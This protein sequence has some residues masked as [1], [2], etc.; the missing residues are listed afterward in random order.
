MPKTKRKSQ[1]AQ[2]GR[3]AHQADRE[4]WNRRFIV[5]GVV[6][7]IVVVIGIIAFGWYQT[8]VKPLGKTVLRVEDTKFSL[9]HFERR[10]RLEKDAYSPDNYVRL[11][12]DVL[13]RLQREA[14]WLEGGG[15]LHASVS[16]SEED[17]TAEVRVRGNLAEDVE[18]NIFAAEFRRQVEQ[19]G[20]RESEYRHILRAELMEG[21][22]RDYFLFVAPDKE[23]QVRAR[24][25][26]LEDEEAAEEALQRLEAGE[27]F[28]VVAE[29]ASLDSAAAAQS[30]ELEWIP[31]GGSFFLPDDVEDFLF[32]AEPGERSEV[33]AV[34]G[35]GLYYIAELLERDDAR[36]LDEQQRRRVAD[37]EMESWLADLQDRLEVVVDFDEDD[38]EK[39]V[40][41]VF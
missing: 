35:V 5:G 8:Q 33:I 17:V 13:N 6:A 24:W 40:D 28:E 41:D 14:L 9:A 11:V 10:V 37:R 23:P 4:Q 20:L 38:L 34:F 36:P 7:V 22:V 12:D 1:P 27:D 39:M 18:Q 25:I 2:R 30:G 29:D 19:S 3:V 31:R 16:V 32:E 15:E 26:L 21:K